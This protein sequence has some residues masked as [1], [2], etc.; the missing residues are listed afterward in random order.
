MA[1]ILYMN[2]HKGKKR[3][4]YVTP[5]LDE[6]SR[7]CKSC[8]FE[9]PDDYEIGKLVE[10]KALMNN[11][12][13]IALTH[14]LFLRMDKESL[15][16]AEDKKY[17]LIVD[18]ELPVACSVHIKP[19]DKKMVL[20]NLA[21]IDSNGRIIWRDSGYKGVFDRYKQVAERGSLFYCG[22]SLF[23]I[24][25][26]D[27]FLPFQEVYLLTYM[28]EGQTQRAY[29][30]YFGFSYNIVGVIKDGENYYFSDKPDVPPPIDYTS[31][32]HIETNKTKN[33]VGDKNFALSAEWYKRRGRKHKDVQSLRKKLNTFFVSYGTKLEQQ[34]WT[35]YKNSE[36]WM[37]GYGNRYASSFLSL[38]ARATNEYRDATH[39]AY[40]VNRFPDPNINKFFSQRGIKIDEDKYALSEML[41]FIW[42]SAI[43]DGKEIHLYVPSQRMRKL[44]IDWITNISQESISGIIA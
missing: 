16:L 13:N 39:V 8:E 25:D 4:L 6:V 23:D 5:Y 33:A 37:Y 17:C 10:L 3:F 7:V 32:I 26:P 21:D 18:E 1:A 12:C 27:K 40:L 20:S 14:A 42:R 35:T 30:D 43:R 22:E 36:K 38:N 11:G 9:E 2:K 15:H 41:Q 31:L 28:F 34:L 19:H 24:L 29:F 44:L